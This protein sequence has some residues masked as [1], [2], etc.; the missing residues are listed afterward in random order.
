MS[1]AR[2]AALAE[3]PAVN[4]ARVAYT[5]AEYGGAAGIREEVVLETL[6]ER[7]AQLFGHGL[8]SPFHLAASYASS[9]IQYRPFIDGN[10]R[11]GFLAAVVFLGLNG[12]EVIAAEVDATLKTLALAAG[13]MTEADYAVWL[14]KKSQKIP[15]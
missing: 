8:T 6:L 3:L 12:F 1:R 13:E 2:S 7:P 15:S 10:K 4:P 11:A 9:I 5:L 14:E